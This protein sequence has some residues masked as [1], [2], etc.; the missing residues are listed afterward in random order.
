MNA[1]QTFSPHEALINW[2]VPWH[3]TE[4]DNQA[5]ETALH[6]LIA[7]CGY[8]HVAVAE[9][10]TQEVPANAYRDGMETVTHGVIVL[11]FFRYIPSKRELSSAARD[12]RAFRGTLTER[13][14][15]FEVERKT[16]P[17]QNGWVVSAQRLDRPNVLSLVA[18]YFI[19]LANRANCTDRSYATSKAIRYGYAS[20]VINALAA[21]K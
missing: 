15:A 18:R 7:D 17:Q 3:E 6:Q 8:T 13:D 21:V 10:R 9:Y 11:D 19:V 2:S 20:E 1:N 16:K 12:V 14:V 4:Q 5:T